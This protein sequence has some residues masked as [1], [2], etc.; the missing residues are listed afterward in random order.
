MGVRAHADEV[1]CEESHTEANG[2]VVKQR[3][4]AREDTKPASK[5]TYHGCNHAC[6]SVCVHLDVYV[7]MHVPVYTHLFVH[8]NRMY[9]RAYD[10]NFT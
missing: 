6:I 5:E 7:Y 10:C 4:T 8:K 9:A 1:C 3:K 2:R